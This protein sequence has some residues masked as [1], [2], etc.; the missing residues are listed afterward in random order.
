MKCKFILS[1][2]LAIA[3]CCNS[4]KDNLFDFDLHHAEADGEWGLPVFN[5][6]IS[7]DRL[8][9]KMDS[10]QYI[11]TGADGV[12]KIVFDQEVENVVSL[13]QIAMRMVTEAGEFTS[14]NLI[15]Q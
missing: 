9:S 15:V 10:I 4:C 12:L 1:L 7:L 5:G 14:L 8:L 11:Q 3:L 2:L 13:S 6:T